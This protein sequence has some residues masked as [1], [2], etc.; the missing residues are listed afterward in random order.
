MAK[1]INT[2]L[3]LKDEFTKNI[4]KASKSASNLTAK[5]KVTE[6][7]IKRTAQSMKTNFVNGAKVAGKAMLVLG[8]ATVT[9]LG[10]ITKET[11]ETL[12]QID[13]VSQRLGL[14]TEAYQKWNYVLSQ[15]GV[16][17][18]TM[19]V[20]LKTLTNTV[21]KAEK[22]GSVAGTAFE[23]LG[24]SIDD[25]KG[26]SRDKIFETTIKALQ[27]VED[28]TQ[29]AILANKLFGK[30]GQNILPLLNQTNASTEELLN[31]A[32]ELGLVIDSDTIQAGVNLTDTIDTLKRSMSALGMQIGATII[33][34]VQRFADY[35]IQHM[36]QIKKVVENV[37]NGIKKLASAV[38]F[39]HDNMNVILPIITAVATALAGWK[40]VA[41]ITAMIET[42]TAIQSAMNIVLG[43]TN[44]TLLAC[45]LTWIIVGI[46]ALIGVLVA[47][48]LK[49]GSFK[50]AIEALTQ[51]FPALN[52]VINGFKNA[53]YALTHPIQTV[54]NGLR[55]IFSYNGKSVN[56]T[57]NT[58][59]HTVTGHATGTS[60]F[61]GGATRINE[62]HRGEIVNL[63]SGSQIIPADKSAKMMNA[64]GGNVTVN[65]T[66]QG[67]VLGNTEFMESC[68]NYI[69]S[70]VI[71]AFGN[72]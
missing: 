18:T 65:V 14:S 11:T 63:P 72:V 23:E 44:T 12:D 64:K 54:V 47:V 53:M 22:A 8:G 9:A 35:V 31:K 27:N 61:K 25:L 3:K 16:D 69:A 45:P 56:I 17:I 36:P 42:W 49:F 5:T 21:G 19:Q 26:A 66:V 59:K 52:G 62:G 38:K 28:G 60:Y 32:E 55:K 33:P 6:K 46:S 39:L 1:T 24:I 30:S 68:G 50:N 37:M 10:K 34:Y 29:K 40:I 15:S 2:V 48:K 51:K 41:I 4:N 13:K 71:G 58:T 7:Q 70:K 67:N 20:G 43:V 57:Q